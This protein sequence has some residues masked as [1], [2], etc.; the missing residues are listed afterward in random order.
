MKPLSLFTSFKPL[1]Y[2]LSSFLAIVNEMQ[3][4]KRTATQ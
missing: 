3:V 1:I 4:K 2:T